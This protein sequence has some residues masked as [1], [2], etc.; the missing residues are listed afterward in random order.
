MKDLRKN[1]NLSVWEYLL[2]HLQTCVAYDFLLPSSSIFL[3]SSCFCLINRHHSNTY[4]GCGF[5]NLQF[6]NIPKKLYNID[7]EQ[8]EKP[9][10]FF[11]FLFIF[12][13]FVF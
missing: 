7:N 10:I 13:F 2:N 4:S 12:L 1:Q 11:L 6:I 9:V 3:I 5:L 8:Q